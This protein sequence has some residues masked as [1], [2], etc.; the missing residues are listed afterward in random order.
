LISVFL[1]ILM[2]CNKYL[3]ILPDDKPVLEDAFKDQYNA[4][5]YLFTCYAS[6]PSFVNPAN[7]LGLTGGGDIIY[8][9]RNTGGGLSAGPPP[10]MMA[11]LKGNNI[12]NPYSNF[13][14]GKNGGKNLWQGIRHCNIFLENI[15]IEDGGP[16]DL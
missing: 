15:R 12:S 14:D 16:R 4:E 6:L 2:G 7:A 13:W 11:F 5:K 3:D 9:E 1:F 10:P 8:N